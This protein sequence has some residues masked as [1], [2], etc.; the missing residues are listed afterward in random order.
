MENI[1]GIFIV[2]IFFKYIIVCS[3]CYLIYKDISVKISDKKVEKLHLTFGKAIL[4]QLNTLKNNKRISTLDI[5][6]T[7][8]KL[9][10]KEY[11]R[12]FNESISIF[13]KDKENYHITRKYMEN[14]EDFIIFNTRLGKRKDNIS[15]AY[16][17]TYLGEY[18]IDS[19]EV[20]EYLINNL[21]SKN[22]HLRTTSLRAISKIGNANNLVNGIKYL[23]LENK[24]INNKVLIDILNQFHGDRNLL[25]D[26]LLE[27]FDDLNAD[28]QKS[29]VENLSHDK[30]INAKV[31][32]LQLLKDCNTHKEVKISIIRYFTRIK[33]EDARSEI[34]KI[35][36][37]EDWDFRAIAATALKHYKDEESINALLNSI[38]DK[39]WH[40]RYN[41]AKS[42]LSFKDNSIVEQVF[43]KNDK[44]SIEILNYIMSSSK[45]CRKEKV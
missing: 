15:K 37:N 12:V 38:G 40:V 23:S 45:K 5:K 43:E 35:L 39:N 21:K 28:I 17:S 42:L 19:F 36:E 14:F 27:I 29:I 22:L 7:K 30:V 44:Y 33:Y 18:K 25:S 16:I 6:Y 13:N 11:I 24:Y 3:V 41:S 8:D 2:L 9:K 4:K 34:I 10:K 31:K 1:S 32:L 20:N 26:K